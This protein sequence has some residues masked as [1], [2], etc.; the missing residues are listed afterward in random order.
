MILNGI[1]HPLFF[2][3]KG[4]ELVNNSFH[5][6]NLDETFIPFEHNGMISKDDYDFAK[7]LNEI[8]KGRDEQYLW[9]YT[10]QK[11]QNVVENDYGTM[12]DITLYRFLKTQCDGEMI[13]WDDNVP[14]FENLSECAKNI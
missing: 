2:S 11:G 3:Y 8:A 9:F 7:L 4:K 10:H 12:D 13:D 1:I 6:Y 14:H 5:C